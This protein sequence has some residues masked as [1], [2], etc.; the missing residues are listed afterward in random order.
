MANLLYRLGHTAFRRRGV[1]V[2]AWALLLAIGIAGVAALGSAPTSGV[3]IPGTE[4]QRALDALSSEFPQASGA[5][6]TVAVRAPAG[7]SVMAPDNKAIV[8]ALVE[9]A[10]ALP[11][12][13]GATSP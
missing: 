13:L 7:Q 10:G 1:V 6:G 3:T 11:G 5:A 4:S 8:L 2:S 12:V 9:K